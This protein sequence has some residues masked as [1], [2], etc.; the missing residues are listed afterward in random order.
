MEIKEKRN[1]SGGHSLGRREGD[2]TGVDKDS[3]LLGYDAVYSGTQTLIAG[4]LLPPTS[5]KSPL[6]FEYTEDRGS[7]L[8]RNFWVYIPT[9]KVSYQK[10]ETFNQR[11]YKTSIREMKK[12][13]NQW[14]TLTALQRRTPNEVKAFLGGS[15]RK[16]NTWG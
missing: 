9:H 5:W 2:S 15:T 6:S 11:C 10:N 16:I 13:A 3:S 14:S 4:E 8:F 12:S 1:S 7:K